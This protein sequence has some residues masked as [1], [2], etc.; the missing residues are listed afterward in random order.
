MGSTETQKAL[1]AAIRQAQRETLNKREQ[2]QRTADAHDRVKELQ[3]TL[4]REIQ[5]ETAE[6]LADPDQAARKP[7][8]KV[9]A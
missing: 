9:A 2:D 5:E 7:R 6:K 4:L 8:Q 1:A 3:V